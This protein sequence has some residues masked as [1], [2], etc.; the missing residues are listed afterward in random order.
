LP[1]IPLWYED[2]RAIMN[3][4]IDGYRLSVNGNYDGLFHVY[5]Q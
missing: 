2:H 3:K 4:N 5:R 1:Y